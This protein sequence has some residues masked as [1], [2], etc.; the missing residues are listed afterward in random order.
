MM[1][2]WHSAIELFNVT[3]DL[4][5]IRIPPHEPWLF[6]YLLLLITNKLEVDLFTPGAYQNLH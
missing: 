6:L 2:V 3:F 1:R 4:S 5:L